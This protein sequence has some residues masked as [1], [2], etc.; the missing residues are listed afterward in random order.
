MTTIAQKIKFGTD[1]WRGVVADDFT[2]DNV[3]LVAQ[4]IA[5][6]VLKLSTGRKL[7]IG[8]D[9]RFLGADFAYACVDV[10]NSKGIDCFL[11]DRPMPTPIA[12]YAIRTKHASGAVML[13]ASHNP[14]DYQGIKF[15][16]SYA[17]PADTEVTDAIETE[18]GAPPR[19]TGKTG[20]TE[21]IS[22][23]DEYWKQL[24][25]LID[26]DLIKRG[27]LRVVVD[28]M[29]GAGVRLLS[30]FAAELSDDVTAIHDS[31]DPLFGG[32]SPDPN[33][34]NLESLVADVAASADVGLAVDGDG[35]R[36]G[37]IDGLGTYL[38]PNQVISLLAFYL[39][40][41]RGLKGSLVRSVATTHLMD[42]I[43][44]DYGAELIETPV[45][46]KWICQEMRRR[47]VVIGGEESGGLSVL[48][49]IPEKDGILA[50]FLAMEMTA[51]MDKKPLSRVLAELYGKYGYRYGIRLDLRLPEERKRPLLE[52]LEKNPPDR[53]EG[54]KV[55]K[56]VNI[57]GV[58]LVLEDGDWLLIRPSGTEP[59]V[60][61][62]I[63]SASPERFSRLQLFAER[64]TK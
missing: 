8:Y 6:Y 34:H 61:T 33:E 7:I 63:E 54:I 16:A 32:R 53:V 29:H 64:L 19:A 27:N 41:R 13:T 11:F 26:F 5:N 25:N 55:A 49:H 31:F 9:A 37:I 50:C 57:D 51:A 48:G 39:L 36:F 21:L 42:D 12:A 2:M 30:V 17:G 43:A 20:K 38:S 40:S 35:D 46:F 45:G 18:I 24:S 10:F 62:Y 60:R 4:A 22:V 28:P 44:A 59:L 14:P 23:I 58:K 52:K 15:I 3:R 1:G 47:P 56:V